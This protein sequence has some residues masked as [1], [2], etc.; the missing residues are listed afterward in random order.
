[1]REAARALIE[2]VHEETE[3]RELAPKAY[4]RAVRELERMRGRPLFHPALASGLGRGARVRLANGHTLIDFASGIGTYGF[5][6]SDPALLE[7][8]VVAAAGDSVFQGH[9]LPGVE[10]HRLSKALLRHAGPHLKHVWLSVSG[11]VAN[12]NALKM[13][14]Q[15]HAP[16]EKIIAFERAFAGRTLAMAEITDKPAY[17]QGLPARDGTLY[18]P[19]FDP[20]DPDSLHKSLAALDAH[21]ARYP[22]RIA[23]ML[24]ELIQ[25][26][27]GFHTAPTEFYAALMNRCREAGI[28]VWVD[29]VQTFARTGEL[30]A[31]KTLGLE[32][33][34]DLVTAG[35]TLQGSAVLFRKDY[36]PRPGLVAGTF[37]G[38]TVGMAVGALI[39][40]RLESEGFLG[41]DGRIAVLGRR[42]DRRLESL[43]KRM[44]RAV[45][46][47][48]GM[49]AMQAFVPF[50][51]A[52]DVVSEVMKA[53]FEQG[54]LIH[55]AG[56]SPAKLRLLLPVNTSDEELES[57]FAMLEKAMRRV[58]EARD[59]PC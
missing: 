14:Y 6:H 19:F 44:P 28:A 31:F 48:S 18:V 58:A 25:G 38:S 52:A 45:G 39:I 43:R 5:G 2:A 8:A 24:F 11:A 12:E 26:E 40:E 13:I 41:P 22:D 30:F 59:L 32:E 15:R 53:A 10:M 17:R 33:L 9:L 51:G 27:G 16:A 37:A 47:R 29:E 35:K 20:G 57:G 42:V 7:A 50:D 34:V 46:P 1:V 55:S 49:G 54:L 3:S 56:A 21:L 36:N 23:G 4:D